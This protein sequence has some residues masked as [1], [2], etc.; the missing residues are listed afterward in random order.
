MRPYDHAGVSTPCTIWGDIIPVLALFAMVLSGCVAGDRS[1]VPG[2]SPN[3]N[4]QNGVAYDSGTVDLRGVRNVTVPNTTIVRRANRSNEGLIVMEKRLGVSGSP[5]TRV[6]IADH[7]KEMGCAY[8][9]EGD[10]LVLGTYG[11]YHVP[12]H[13]GAS[14]R[15]VV[16][17]PDGATV[18]KRAEPIR[19]DSPAK[20]D[21]A[22]WHR[23]GSTPV[24]STEASLVFPPAGGK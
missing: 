2:D 14:V 24:D 15:L 23:L 6:S 4:I 11:E 18:D 13:G 16:Y 17:L 3:P 7:R 1:V 22:P 12:G 8:K 10:S 9:R 19:A 20:K 5:P 21:D